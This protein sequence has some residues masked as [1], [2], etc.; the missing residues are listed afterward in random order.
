MQEASGQCAM[1]FSKKKKTGCCS[2]FHGS[3][4]RKEWTRILSLKKR[5]RIDEENVGQLRKNGWK[6]PGV[7]GLT[8]PCYCWE[9]MDEK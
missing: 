1:P 4:T 8:Y 5:E 7:S 9:R 2:S 6:T 3:V